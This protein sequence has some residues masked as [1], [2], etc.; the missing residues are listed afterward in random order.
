MRA[1]YT[2]ED[3]T[4]APRRVVMPEA[5]IIDTPIMPRLI[6]GEAGE[7]RAEAITSMALEMLGR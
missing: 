6:I 4:S 5:Y 3:S 2:A 7:P 1:T